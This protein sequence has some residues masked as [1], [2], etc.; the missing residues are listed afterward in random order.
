[1]IN[2]WLYITHTH[3]T[4]SFVW[5]FLNHSRLAW[6]LLK[7]TFGDN[8]SR[9]FL[10]TS[11]PSTSVKAVRRIHLD[12]IFSQSIIWFLREGMASILLLISQMSSG[13]CR[14]CCGDG[15]GCLIYGWL[16]VVIAQN[17]LCWAWLAGCGQPASSRC[18]VVEVHVF[19]HAHVS[20]ITYCVD[21]YRS[22][23]IGASLLCQA[24]KGLHTGWLGRDTTCGHGLTVLVPF[25]TQYSAMFYVIM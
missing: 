16:G 1:M 18:W 3:K 10:Q 7:V 22:R 15:S 6:F 19:T 12:V 14:Q 11:R 13:M 17:F 21:V 23:P 8:C 25:S 2:I 4:H 20:M 5:L 9:F 24:L